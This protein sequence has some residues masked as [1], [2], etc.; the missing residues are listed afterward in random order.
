MR[1]RDNALSGECAD[2]IEVIGV[3]FYDLAADN[4]TRLRILQAA[5]HAVEEALVYPL[6]DE[7]NHQF[8]L[9]L[10]IVSD[11]LDCTLQLW[12]LNG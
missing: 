9:V 3:G 11:F 10:L 1:W 2:Q 7:H 12:H 4:S 8:D 5:S 6:I